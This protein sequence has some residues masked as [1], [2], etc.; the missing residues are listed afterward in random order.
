MN[1]IPTDIVAF[2]LLVTCF[3][4][5]AGSPDAGIPLANEAVPAGK[6]W[7]FTF[8]PYLWAAGLEGETGQRPLGRLI[9]F[10]PVGV[11]GWSIG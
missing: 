10:G 3:S 6:D 8:V 9:L 7:H 1:V 11:R 5:R 2:G 4:A